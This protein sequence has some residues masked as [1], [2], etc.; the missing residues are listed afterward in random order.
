PT[1]HPQRHPDQGRLT[2]PVSRAFLCEAWINF[3]GH[4]YMRHHGPDNSGKQR[5]RRNARRISLPTIEPGNP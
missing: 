4:I 2:Q 5:T 3:R 1:Q